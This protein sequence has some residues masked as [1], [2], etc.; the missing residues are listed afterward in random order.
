MALERI[1][2]SDILAVIPKRP[3]MPTE[4]KK[5]L[6]PMMDFPPR[7]RGLSFAKCQ[8]TAENKTAIKAAKEWS[9][10]K[11]ENL[12]LYG[13]NGTGK[14]HIACAAMAE[15][16]GYPEFVNVPTMLL[17]FQ[18]SV[19]DHDELELIGQYTGYSGR[20]SRPVVPLR[21]FDDVAAHRISDF[22]LEMFGIMLEKMYSYCLSG[23]IFTSNLS[24]K[25]I[26]ETMGERIA[27]RLMGLARAVK[28][29]GDD[30]RL[31]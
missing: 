19:H 4:S 27:S 20:F 3:D 29:E 15:R 7:Y 14:T 11:I 22:G 23:M 2:Q 10:G 16:E 1:A 25:Q 24:P 6:N 17:K 31:K 8:E 21:L 18:A 30:W 12:L 13:L 28:V 26:H 9:D 5:I